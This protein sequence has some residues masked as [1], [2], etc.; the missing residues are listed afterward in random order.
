MCV[1]LTSA[2]LLLNLLL[3]TSYKL[4]FQVEA[5]TRQAFRFNI[6]LSDSITES[7]LNVIREG[8]L[9][10][11]SKSKIDFIDKER[12]LEQF[13]KETGEE[14]DSVLD[15]N[16]IP[17]TLVITFNTSAAS[18]RSFETLNSKLK[19]LPGVE[20]TQFEKEL[21]LKSAGY[22][23]RVKEYLKWG[24]G[25]L[26]VTIFILLA[27]MYDQLNIYFQVLFAPV[28]KVIRNF[29]FIRM[30]YVTYFLFI[31]FFSVIICGTVLTL[32]WYTL[33]LHIKLQ[34]YNIFNATELAVALSVYF[35]V[36]FLLPLLW[37][38]TR[39]RRRIFNPRMK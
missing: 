29:H 32:V 35:M 20:D 39:I 27:G 6:F 30:I 26:I 13:I 15:Y 24:M 12:A 8:I 3:F 37:V 14:I 18:D 25:I 2:G 36:S 5:E 4:S 31:A 17:A 9:S 10:Y 16:P 28:Q 22:L 38:I 33:N 7:Q 19:K 1:F 34:Q 11:D 21:L 23:Q